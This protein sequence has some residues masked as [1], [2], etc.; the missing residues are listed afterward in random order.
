MYINIVKIMEIKLFNFIQ[1][2]RL[3]F[4]VFNGI[5]EVSVETCLEETITLHDTTSNDTQ[6]P[7]LTNNTG[8]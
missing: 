6:K 2:G 5:W 8:Q 4:H 1:T 3:I 7:Y